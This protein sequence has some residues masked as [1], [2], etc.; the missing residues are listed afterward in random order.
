MTLKDKS[1]KMKVQRSKLNSLF[2]GFKVQVLK[3]KA[4]KILGKVYLLFMGVLGLQFS[5]DY[6]Y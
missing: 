1:S 5:E 3:D 6:L 4:N 2:A